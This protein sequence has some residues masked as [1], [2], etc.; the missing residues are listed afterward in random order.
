MTYC[1][2]LPESSPRP[3]WWATSILF[4]GSSSH[5]T[6]ARWSHPPDSLHN[7]SGKSSRARHGSGSL[8]ASCL[9]CSSVH[10]PLSILVLPAAAA[11]AAAAAGG[12]GAVH[13]QTAAEQLCVIQGGGAGHLQPGWA[14]IGWERHQACQR[15][16][17]P[18][19][20]SHHHRSTWT[21]RLMHRDTFTIRHS[22]IVCAH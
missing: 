19:V 2:P 10:F 5:G 4:L 14:L 18:H 3:C 21:N 9:Y 13:R 8:T 6:S 17:H 11:A 16:H 15:Q 22:Y 20:L 12:D 1:L 7:P